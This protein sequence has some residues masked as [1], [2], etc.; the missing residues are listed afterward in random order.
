MPDI[1]SIVKNHA[2]NRDRDAGRQQGPQ[3]L[4]GGWGEALPPTPHVRSQWGSGQQVLWRSKTL[5]VGSELPWGPYVVTKPS[6][7][8]AQAHGRLA[9]RREAR[10]GRKGSPG[11][12]VLDTCEEQTDAD[13]LTVTPNI[14]DTLTHPGTQRY[15][16][17]THTPT[18]L[19][20]PH[21]TTHNDRVA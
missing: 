1:R 21:D 13:T 3:Q 20:T 17:D 6:Q 4:V 10:A 15:N 18:R 14:R 5:S 9:H 8:Q 19:D 12:T 2:L 7:T 11:A 16:Q